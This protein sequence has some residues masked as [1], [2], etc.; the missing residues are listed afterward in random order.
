MKF[1][2]TSLY[3][4][5]L[6]VF[7]QCYFDKEGILYPDLNCKPSV[8]PSFSKDIMPILNAR[9]NNCHSGSFPSGNIKLETYDDVMKRVSNGSLMGSIRQTGGFSPMPKNSSKLS[10]CDIQKIAD[11]IAMGSL[12]N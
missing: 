9:C 2:L 10:A 3:L 7:T 6:F 11:W 12:N 5:L 4:F 8:N 1:R